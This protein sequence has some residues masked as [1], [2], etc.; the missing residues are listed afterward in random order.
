M[1]VPWTTWQLTFA[2][3]LVLC[4][5]AAAETDPPGR[6]GRIGFISGTVSLHTADEP[7][8]SPAPLNFPITSG[9]SLWTEPD[10]RTE[11][12]IGGD[13]IRLDG[14]TEMTV[15]RLDDSAT[16]I[17]VRQGVVNVHMHTLPPG[18]VIV[19]TPLGDV[20][21][22][23]AGS[24]R[25]DAGRPNGATPPDRIE[26]AALEGE[27]QFRGE[28]TT[29]QIMAGRSARLGGNPM[30]MSLVAADA[31]PFDDWARERDRSDVASESLGFVGSDMTGASDLDRFGHWRDDPSFGHLWFPDS[32]PAG[33][34]P[35]RFGHWAFVRPWGWTWIDHAPWGFAPFHFGRWA[36]VGGRWGWWPGTRIVAR[37]V[38]APA[39]VAFFGGSN[40]AVAFA[41]GRP[42]GAVGFVPLAPHEAFHPFFPASAIFVRNVNVA[43]VD[44]SI[45]SKIQ[46]VTPETIAVSA[47][48]NRHAAIVVPS[49]AF[50]RAV[51]VDGSVIALSFDAIAHRPIVADLVHLRP[52]AI[53]RAGIVSPS[54]LGFLPNPPGRIA[55][56]P[57][58]NMIFGGRQL[59]IPG[60]FIPEPIVPRAP[61]PL[62]RNLPILTASFLVGPSLGL[63]A[64]TG[65]VIVRRGTPSA[66]MP[67]AGITHPPPPTR[68]M[69]TSQVGFRSGLRMRGG[70]FTGPGGTGGKAGIGTSTPSFSSGPGH[71]HGHRRG[72]R[73]HR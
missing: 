58:P 51:P 1:R 21:L 56:M 66:V 16:Q 54:T 68:A 71:A 72:H 33:W 39:L 40:F 38:F 44:Q 35:F 55:E 7:N 49:L 23:R 12:Q 32:V 9:M 22:V 11:I 47:F 15:L 29:L 45:F 24:Y 34:A 18:G 60:T 6:V 4:G 25:I 13:E 59:L 70:A 63:G 42:F 61:G 19:T 8:W 10:S 62:I 67:S 57:A 31:T 14:G 3:L 69:L 43:V 53:A 46:V 37:P 27:A 48:A 5:S 52:T 36:F 73:G 41:S 26:V 65:S 50:T 20:D 17:D 28:R 2:A 64:V 30:T